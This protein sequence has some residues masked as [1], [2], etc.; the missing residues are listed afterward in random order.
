MNITGCLFYNIDDDA[1]NIHSVGTNSVID[2]NTIFSCDTAMRFGTGSIPGSVTIQKNIFHQCTYDMYRP[3]SGSYTLLSPLYNIS[4]GIITS[5]SLGVTNKYNVNPLFISEDLTDPDFHLQTRAGGYPID[6]IAYNYPTSGASIGCY[7]DT[8]TYTETWTAFQI[9]DPPKS[10]SI[11]LKSQNVVSNTSLNGNVNEYLSE[12]KRVFTLSFTDY[13][14]RYQTF[15]LIDLYS[16][17]QAMR[18]Y[19]LGLN[20]PIFSSSGAY[21][22]TTKTLTFGYSTPEI[23]TNWF[24]GWWCTINGKDYY[25]ASNTHTTLTL[26][27]KLSNG[28]TTGTYYFD[29]NYILVKII[30]EDISLDCNYFINY[31]DGQSL[32][33]QENSDLPGQYRLEEYNNYTITL[34]EVED[35]SL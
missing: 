21:N 1:I 6:S 3:S 20:D 2:Y 34:Q 4:N 11:V 28:L 31:K 35:Y 12:I 7:S 17:T 29:I 22:S 27:D 26:E 30:H 25:I 32:S 18:F 15:K 9:I 5:G 24:K 23:P 33:L 13:V 14:R 10:H 8:S 19:P 16:D